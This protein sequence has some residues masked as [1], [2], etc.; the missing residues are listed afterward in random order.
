MKGRNQKGMRRLIVNAVI[1]AVVMALTFWSVFRGQDFTK[2]V[3]AVRQMSG[4]HM[5]AAGIF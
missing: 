4:T 1:F 2:I 3:A 5:A